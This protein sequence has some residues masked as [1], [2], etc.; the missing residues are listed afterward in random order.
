M[1]AMDPLSISASIV[2]L[3]GAA[4]TASKA[5]EKLI[6]LRKAPEQL[7]QLFNEVRSPRPCLIC[8]LAACDVETQLRWKWHL[9]GQDPAPRPKEQS[10]LGWRWEARSSRLVSSAITSKQNKLW[11]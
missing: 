4:A 7:R 10:M 5:I 6:S 9:G 8:G 1:I 3:M 11:C 2:A